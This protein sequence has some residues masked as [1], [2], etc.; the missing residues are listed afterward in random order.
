MTEKEFHAARWMWAVIDGKVMIATHGDDRSHTEWLR[1]LVAEVGLP[2]PYDT[3]FAGLTR[4]YVY[5][6]KL[7]AYKG[8]D[9]SRYVPLREVLLALDELEKVAGPI[10]TV[11]LGVR[12]GGAEQPWATIADAT[13]EEFRRHVEGR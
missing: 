8:T 13:A 12:A 11:G 6:G 3:F 7:A 9:F 10:H 1:A 2:V 5:N 4:G